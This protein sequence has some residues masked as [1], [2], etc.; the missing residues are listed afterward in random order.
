[1][2]EFFKAIFKSVGRV[3]VN[4]QEFRGNQIIIGSRG[5]Q[6]GRDVFV[7]GSRLSLGANLKLEIKV[8]GDVKTLTTSSGDISCLN[9]GRITTASGD[10]KCADINGNVSTAS[11]DV[12]A[13]KITGDVNT[14]SGD[15]SLN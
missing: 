11:G 15:V 8:E 7:N 1:M 2:F 4:G 12:S 5:V 14:M 3:T 6:S 9:V 10:I 13:K